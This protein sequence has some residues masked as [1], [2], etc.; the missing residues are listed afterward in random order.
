MASL[1]RFLE[2]QLQSLDPNWSTSIKTR[3]KTS[4]AR[5]VVYKPLRVGVVDGPRM[6]STLPQ[7]FEFKYATWASTGE[8]SWAK[9]TCSSGRKE[10]ENIQLG[11]RLKQ[12]SRYSGHHLY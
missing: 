6:S 10:Q 2:E 4:A 9:Q 11:Y 7:R 8:L 5:L 12:T 1:A 3:P